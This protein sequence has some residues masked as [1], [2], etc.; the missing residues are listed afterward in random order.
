MPNVQLTGN[1][2]DFLKI[3][4]A[5]AGRGD[6][7]TV[8]QLLDDKPAWIHTVGSHGRT[9]LWEAAYRGK[10]A[11][12]QFLLERDADINLPGC[13]LSKHG[14]EITPYCVARHEGRDLVADYL[15]QQGATI[16][17]HTAAY[18]GDYDTVRSHLDNDRS[19][20]NSGYLQVVML[21]SGGPTTFE[22]RETAWATPLC[23]AIMGKN[24]AI[25]EL[26][27]SRGAVI[28]R[29]SE[30]FLDYATL[31]DRV[32]IAK[33]LLENG[34]DPNKAPRI[35]DDGSEISA[36]FKHYG[37]P[38]KDIN[39]KNH[40]GWPPLVYACRGDNGEHPDEVQTL[41]DLGADIDVRNYKGKTALHY[42][43]KAGF[44]KVINLL[45]EKGATVDATDQDG[46]TPLFEAIRSTIKDGEKQ[47]AALEA[48]LVKGANPNLRNQKG[49]TVLQV[50]QRIRRAEKEK[51][52]EL[53]QASN[54]V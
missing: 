42:A 14:I 48:L 17:I 4:V 18:L 1:Q 44:L 13:H 52:V 15:L 50:A 3:V 21:P 40:M 20:V 54:A 43:A 26:L 32:E 11:V 25:V 24:P 22:H 9:M 39:A 27:I 23:Y 5:A 28:K 31:D 47:R 29:Y 10:L 53:L 35:L 36:L 19:L 6:L 49:L 41:L 37:V 34:A 45:I 46:E 12:V 30:R 16:D 7:E 33:L 2:S 8:R 51:V 38:P